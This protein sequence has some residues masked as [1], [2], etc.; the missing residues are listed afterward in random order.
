MRDF[1]QSVGGIQATECSEEC[2]ACQSSAAAAEAP[3]AMLFSVLA[4]P[5]LAC[6]LGHPKHQKG[7]RS[8]STIRMRRLR[9]VFDYDA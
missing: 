7:K 5:P 2:M 6:E 9:A 8:A 3:A 4:R 1:S